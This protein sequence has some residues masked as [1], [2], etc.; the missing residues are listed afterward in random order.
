M[1]AKRQYQVERTLKGT[2][3]YLVDARSAADAVRTVLDG[4]GEAVTFEITS[5]ARTATATPVD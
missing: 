2:Q 3:V 5:A 1:S 4:G